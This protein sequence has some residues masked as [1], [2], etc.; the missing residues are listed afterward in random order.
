MFLIL[1]SLPRLTL[2][3][4]E[5]ILSSFRRFELVDISCWAT[6]VVEVLLLLFCSN[7]GEGEW[8]EEVGTIG[9]GALLAIEWEEEDKGSGVELFGEEILRG[10]DD[11]ATVVLLISGVIT[12]EVAGLLLMLLLGLGGGTTGA[13]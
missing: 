1:A 6:G 4:T 7:R 9:T 11:E 5:Q 3:A 10:F 2:L 8:E 12:E 13:F